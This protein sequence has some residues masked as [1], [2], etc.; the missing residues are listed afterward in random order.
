MKYRNTNTGRA[1]SKIWRVIIS[2]GVIAVCNVV[3]PGLVRADQQTAPP[4]PPPPPPTTRVDSIT[5]QEIDRIN[6]VE[7][8]R[9]NTIYHEGVEALRSGDY[10]L[11]EEKFKE[12]LSD[13]ETHA[14][15]N[16]YMGIIRVHQGDL[17][18]ARKHLKAAVKRDPYYVEAR[19]LLALVSINLGDREEA[20][21]QLEKLQKQQERCERKSCAN[22]ARIDQAVASVTQGLASTQ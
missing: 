6:D 3:A 2:L 20:E 5:P 11:A 8:A 4:P 9:I 15:S 13:Y 17:S 22:Q 14:Q 12:I 21:A 16:Y 10:A 19:E 1:F 7:L 18:E